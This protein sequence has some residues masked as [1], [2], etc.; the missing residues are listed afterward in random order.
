MR[1][2]TPACGECMDRLS[3][4]KLKIK[5]ADAKGVPSTHFLE[6]K[7]EL[8]SYIASHFPH[9][10]SSGTIDDYYKLSQALMEVNSNLWSLEDEI[11]IYVNKKEVHA[12]DAPRIVDIALLIPV[13]NDKRAELV[14]NISSLAKGVE[15]RPEKVY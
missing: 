7:Q 14:R 8:E 1:I 6:E 13:L 12:V 9:I 11:R 4:L 10:G 2:I 3:I 15:V 5:S